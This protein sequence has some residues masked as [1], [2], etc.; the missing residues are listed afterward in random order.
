MMVLGVAAM[1]AF[2]SANATFLN[3]QFTVNR[4][5]AQQAAN[6][7]DSVMAEAIYDLMSDQTFG[8]DHKKTIQMQPSRYVTATLTFDPQVAAQNRM[9]CSY[10]NWA[11]PTAAPSPAVNWPPSGTAP[12]GKVYQIPPGAVLLSAQCVANGVPA[13]NVAMVWFPQFPY[14]VA[15]SGKVS[16][17]GGLKVAAASPA[18]PATALANATGRANMA[19]NFSTGLALDLLSG[20]NVTGN[21]EAVGAVHVASGAHVAGQVLSNADPVGL[22]SITISSLDPNT[23]PNV[24]PTPLGNGAS[25]PQL[26]GF[27]YASPSPGAPLSVTGDLNFTNDGVLYVDGDLHVTGA[28][29]GH[30]VVVTTGAATIDQGGS[31]TAPNVAAI[32]TGGDLKITGNSPSNSAFAGMLY[33]QGNFN[34]TD[35]TLVGVMA[36]AGTNSA[37]TLNT[38]NVIQVPSYSRMSLN[39]VNTTQTF[40]YPSSNAP[41]YVGNNSTRVDM[42][43][44]T[45]S[46]GQAVWAIAQLPNQP[47]VPLSQFWGVLANHLAKVGYNGTVPTSTPNWQNIDTLLDQSSGQQRT[48]PTFLGYCNNLGPPPAGQQQQQGQTG[49]SQGSQWV[50]DLNQFISPADSLRLLYWYDY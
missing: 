17:S 4:Q 15:A 38:T 43:H 46:S 34:A 5:S 8:Q 11:P 30:G 27:N 2:M 36:G 39:I 28:V 26:S 25:N 1:A 40:T 16:T 20:A 44:Y 3:L 31:L 22:P 29:T 33:T 45:D 19:S 18:P 7:A 48:W 50:L 47:P 42:L 13:N 21:A 32:V 6:Q 14:A 49:P 37:V 24:T 23:L 9:L 10:N 12:D 41:V 35:I